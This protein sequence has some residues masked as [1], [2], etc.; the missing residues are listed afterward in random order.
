MRFGALEQSFLAA[1]EKGQ[2]A[3]AHDA[4]HRGHAGVDDVDALVGGGLGDF[5]SRGRTDRAVEQDQ[6]ARRGAFDNAI[7]AEHAVEHFLIGAHDDVDDGACLADFLRRVQRLGALGTRG[8]L[9]FGGDVEADRR[10]V[11]QFQSRQQ[12]AAH[13][14]GTDKANFFH[15][16]LLCSFLISYV[17]D[18]LC[19]L[20]RFHHEGTARRSRN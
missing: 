15:R 18:V 8:F 19:L 10:D 14:A 5:F 20:G 11:G 7:F 12:P 4:R 6:R 9:A 16:S 17:G 1:D 2:P 3:L 13:G